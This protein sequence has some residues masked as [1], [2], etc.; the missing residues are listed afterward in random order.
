MKDKD[1]ICAKI[2]IDKT[3]A[4][5][6]LCARDEPQCFQILFYVID[7]SY[8]KHGVNGP[9][10]SIHDRQ[11]AEDDKPK[12]QEYIDLLY[13]IVYWQDAL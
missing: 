4:I 7:A 11:G 6:L 5:S 12:P 8:G 9:L 13:K 10:N 1:A 2:L 3:G